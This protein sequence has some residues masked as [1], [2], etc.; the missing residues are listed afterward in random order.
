MRPGPERRPRIFPLLSPAQSPGRF[1]AEG[2]VLTAGREE[3]TDCPMLEPDGVGN[4]DSLL[5]IAP[6]LQAR[7]E[8][9]CPP[10]SAGVRPLYVPEGC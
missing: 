3:R 10:P 7:A 6:F 1:S 4:D 8:M 2:D 9:F 5:P